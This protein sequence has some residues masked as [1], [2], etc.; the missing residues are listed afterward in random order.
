MGKL[1]AASAIRP[2]SPTGPRAW[3]GETTNVRDVVGR[4]ISRNLIHRDVPCAWPRSIGYNLNSD[5]VVRKK[6]HDT[7]R[8][9]LESDIFNFHFQ[10][11]C[12]LEYFTCEILSYQEDF[13]NCRSNFSSPT[14]LSRKGRSTHLNDFLPTGITRD[15]GEARWSNPEMCCERHDNRAVRATFNRRLFHRDDIV[16]LVNFLH[17]LFVRTRFCGYKNSHHA[18]IRGEKDAGPPP[19]GAGVMP[20]TEVTAKTKSADLKRSTTFAKKSKL[21]SR[22]DHCE[23]G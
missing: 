20:E 8:F 3:S 5:L 6:S 16:R 17:T 21:M 2:G 19:Y 11:C 9:V 18:R 4:V 12:G 14:F 22:G 13:F 23:C 7:V 15:D 10:L 1:R